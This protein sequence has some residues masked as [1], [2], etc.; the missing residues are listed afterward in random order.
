MDGD[1]MIKQT[2][3]MLGIFRDGELHTVVECPGA[4]TYFSDQI[5]TSIEAD[6]IETLMA[7][8]PKPTAEKM[9]HIFHSKRDAELKDMCAKIGVETKNLDSDFNVIEVEDI[10][11][12]DIKELPFPK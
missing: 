7:G 3:Q 12:K 5:Y 10:V 1:S 4:T 6:D 2:K 9:K 11:I 8:K